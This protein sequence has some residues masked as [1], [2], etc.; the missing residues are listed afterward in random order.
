MHK[1]S[2]SYRLAGL[3]LSLIISIGGT[4]QAETLRISGTGVALGGIILLGDAFEA[5]NPG[6]TIE[7]LPSLGSSGGIKALLAGALG[8]SV[9]SRPL[10]D[11]EKEGGAMA[12]I[13]A[14]TPSQ[15]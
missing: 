4:A 8:L 14:S 10:K 15:L 7:V 2:P 3:A 12:K 13:Y 6:T 1:K 11:D 5:E 9:S